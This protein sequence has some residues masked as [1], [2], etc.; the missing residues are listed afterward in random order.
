MSRRERRREGPRKE[1]ELVMRSKRACF[2]CRFSFLWVESAR[3]EEHGREE[4]EVVV[5]A[6]VEGK[7]NATST[8][9]V[10]NGKGR[11]PYMSL[12]PSLFFL[13]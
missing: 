13:P 2:C 6:D 12:F 9:G 7:K 3:G 4:E 10:L 11:R 8:S 1:T 5:R